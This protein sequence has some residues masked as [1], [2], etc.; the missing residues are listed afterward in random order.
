MEVL[1]SDDACET[2]NTDIPLSASVVK[3]RRLTP[4]T[5][6]IDRPVTVIRVVPLMLLMPLM[7]F[8]SSSI[9]SLMSVP[10]CVGLK[11]FLTRMGMCL[12]QTG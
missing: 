8:R 1:F 11:V 4:M 7:G 10:G 12:M 2:M 6:T 9:L 3:M 5:P